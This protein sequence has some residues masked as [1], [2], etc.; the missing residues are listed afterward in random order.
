MSKMIVPVTKEII[1]DFLKK[2]NNK[3]FT[4]NHL[5][6]RMKEEMGDTYSVTF[7]S[8]DKWVEVLIAEKRI[9][10]Q[11]VGRIQIFWWEE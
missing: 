8:I 11:F 3:R 2:N 1:F 5:L 9:K 6:N 4:K 10:A 7:N